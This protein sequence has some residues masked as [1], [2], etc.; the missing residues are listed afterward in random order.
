[1]DKE[2]ALKGIKTYSI[3]KRVSKVTIND[4]SRPMEAGQGMDLFFSSLPDI[5]AGKIFRS[6][7]N[8]VVSAHR[9]Q[10]GVI[11]A[12]GAHVIKC[13][14]NPILIDLVEKSI[15]TALVVNGACLVHDFE[16]AFF[17]RTSEDVEKGLN[18]GE[19]GMAKETGSM[20]N[21]AINEGVQKGLGIGEAVGRWIMEKEPDFLEYSILAGAAK[22]GIP[23]T[24]HIAIG[25]DIIHMHPEADG[26]FLGIGCLRDFHNLT[27]IIKTL[28]NGGIYFNIGSAV[29]L[30]EVFL[31]AVTMVINLGNPLKD[32]TTVNM[33][34]IQHYRPTQNVVKRPVLGRGK[35]YTLIGHHEIMIP[36]LA[37]GIKEGI[38]AK[39]NNEAGQVD[40]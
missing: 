32:F 35:G 31:K 4:F 8:A 18:T 38:S 28:D 7:I 33:D 27:T 29:I 6:V 26:E 17:G 19:F 1:M 12:I 11:W 30:P 5:L 36:L 23:I 2:K 13:G 10:R 20:L 39:D 9:K 21:K 14:L 37:A 22:K 25:T 34:F 40:A 3:N 16:I 24:A 15:I